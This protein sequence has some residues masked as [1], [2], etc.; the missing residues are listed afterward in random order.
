MWFFLGKKKSREKLRKSHKKRERRCI[1]SCLIFHIYFFKTSQLLFLGKNLGLHKTLHFWPKR[2]EFQ[3]GFLRSIVVRT[4]D[5][6]L[7]EIPF[8]FFFS[9]FVWPLLGFPILIIFGVKKKIEILCRCRINAMKRDAIHHLEASSCA[10]Q[11]MQWPIGDDYCCCC[12]VIKRDEFWVW[13][14]RGDF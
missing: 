8:F 6:R 3:K 11:W 4:I 2:I 14:K 12:C 9:P 7:I 5:R 13:N 1:S 10:H